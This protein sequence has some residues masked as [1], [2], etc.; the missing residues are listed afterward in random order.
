MSV[1]DIVGECW[2]EIGEE[3]V[4]LT[5]YITHV[6]RARISIK[7]DEGE[8]DKIWSNC[9]TNIALMRRDDNR[10]FTA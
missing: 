8:V 7:P 3:V 2:R 5:A 1:G 6:V 4:A 9:C 10:N